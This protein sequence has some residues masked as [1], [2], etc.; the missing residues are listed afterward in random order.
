MSRLEPGMTVR[1]V[2][3]IDGET[4][5]F[6]GRTC[7]LQEYR[8]DSLFPGRKHRPWMSDIPDGKGGFWWFSGRELEAVSP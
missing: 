8:H 1:I 2:R 3:D 4:P 6:V 5:E 7:L